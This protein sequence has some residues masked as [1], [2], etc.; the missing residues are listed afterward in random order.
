MLPSLCRAGATFVLALMASSPTTS[1]EEN[2]GS[3]WSTAAPAEVGLDPGPLQRMASAI[4]AGEFS[5]I[6]SV[7]VARRGRLAFEEYFGGA[8]ASDLM[9][10]RSATKTIAGMLVGIAIERGELAGVD[11][12]VLGTLRRTGP[13]AHPD[14][15]KEAMT[16]EDLLTMSSL[17]ECDDWNQFSRGNEERMYLVEDWVGFF[18][19][20]PV[21]GFPPWAQKPADS[22]YGRS[23]SYCTAGVVTLGAVLEA[24]TGTTVEAYAAAHLFSPLGIRGVRWP[25]SPLGLAVTGGGL[26]LRARDLLRLGQLYLDEGESGGRAV[27]PRSW[28]RESTRPHVSIDETTEYGYLW[29]LRT[30]EAGGRKFPAFYMSGNGGN[31]VAVFPEQG[32]VV[33]LTSTNYSTRGMHEQTDRLL[34]DFILPAVDTATASPER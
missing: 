32:L 25:K 30:F 11:A 2:A 1:A 34:T 22:P 5:K 19:D 27:V 23:F 26:E 18:L 8:A 31:K 15:R 21:K 13:I 6:T 4:R 3:P 28:V 29:W 7:L 20:L 16:V 14:P 10:T 33:V 24:A 17:L 12:R 9:N